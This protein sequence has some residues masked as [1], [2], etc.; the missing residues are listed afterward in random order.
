MWGRQCLGSRFVLFYC[1]L[2]CPGCLVGIF[3][4]TK[5]F[6]NWGIKQICVSKRSLE[7][8]FEKG[9]K[10]MATSMSVRPLKKSTEKIEGLKSIKEKKLKSKLSLGLKDIYKDCNRTECIE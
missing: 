3:Q 8:F 10:M 5:K 7:D 1:V 2:V 6:S 9:L 4:K